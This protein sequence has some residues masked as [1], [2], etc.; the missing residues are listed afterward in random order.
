MAHLMG[1]VDAK[2]LLERARQGDRYAFEQVLRPLVEPAYRLALAMLDEREAA[3]DAPMAT[4]S[5]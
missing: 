3:E 4:R 1:S 5:T 2:S